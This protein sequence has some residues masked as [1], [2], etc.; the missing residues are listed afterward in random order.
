MHHTEDVRERKSPFVTFLGFAKFRKGILSL[1]SVC[2]LYVYALTCIH[3]C[4]HLAISQLTACKMA[5]FISSTDFSCRHSEP[6]SFFPQHVFR[7]NQS[8][9]TLAQT[10]HN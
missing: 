2:V 9:L 7:R 10:K 4:P 5:K 3:I 1:E 6:P 8:V